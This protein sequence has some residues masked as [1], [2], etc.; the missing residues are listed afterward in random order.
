MQTVDKAGLEAQGADGPPPY[1]APGS[2]QG[3]CTPAAPSIT[4][5]PRPQPVSVHS[6]AGQSEVIWGMTNLTGGISPPICQEDSKRTL[7]K[8]PFPP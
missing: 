4:S 6:K 3:F 1:R 8:A 7:E 5:E 2:A